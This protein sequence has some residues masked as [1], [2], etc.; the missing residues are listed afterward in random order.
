MPTQGSFPRLQDA[1]LIHV[2]LAHYVW[3]IGEHLPSLNE[4]RSKVSQHHPGA[5]SIR[6]SV[7][8]LAGMSTAERKNGS[9]RAKRFT[10]H[11]ANG[12][13]QKPGTL[14]VLP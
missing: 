1:E 5:K 3:A 7:R 6:D 8:Q 9:N 2:V 11:F 13:H 10:K 4:R 12:H 14:I